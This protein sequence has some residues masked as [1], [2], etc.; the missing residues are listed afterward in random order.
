M[1]LLT[2]LAISIGVLGGLATWA[3]VGPMAS[4]GLQ[5]WAAF[6]AWAAFYH[7]GGG[8]AALK[9]NIPAHI[10]GAIVGWASLW[11]IT[12]LA[13]G[14]G[15]PVAGGICVAIGAAVIVL[16]ANIAA[17]G[18]IP[19]SVYGFGC[20][21]G[22]TLLAG[23]L[24]TL[25]SGSIVDNPLINIAVSMIIGAVLGFISQKIGAAMAKE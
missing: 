22:Y 23:K 2:A 4:L 1:P 24:G 12:L 16:A 20:V 11:A 7:S 14:L 19:S 13:P 5:I 18:S 17:L 15:V 10:F 21:A 3:F 25:M 6:I 9:S 8:A